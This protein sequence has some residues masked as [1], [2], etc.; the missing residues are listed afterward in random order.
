MICLSHRLA[1][2]AEHEC[3]ILSLDGVHLRRRFHV[4]AAFF[5]RTLNSCWSFLI[6]LTANPPNRFLV[7]RDK[8]LHEMRGCIPSCRC[9]C[10]GQW[11]RQIC[12]FWVS[13]V[14]ALVKSSLSSLAVEV[15]DFRFPL[16]LER[17]GEEDGCWVVVDVGPLGLQANT[18]RVVQTRACLRCLSMFR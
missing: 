1:R 5:R 7:L 2:K 6:H 9:Q 14:L 8:N 18:L 16:M 12:L 11:D 13:S 17:D 4:Q 10:E 15:S 3:G